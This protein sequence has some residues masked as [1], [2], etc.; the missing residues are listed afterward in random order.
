MFVWILRARQ[1][2]QNAQKL[3]L[4]RVVAAGDHTFTELLPLL[5]RKSP[6]YTNHSSPGLYVELYPP[7]HSSFLAEWSDQLGL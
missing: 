2:P 6:F 3:V 4:Q 7:I 1:R 5:I